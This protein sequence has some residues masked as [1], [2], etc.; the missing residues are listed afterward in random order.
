MY[1]SHLA[2]REQV[3]KGHAKRTDVFL[4]ACVYIFLDFF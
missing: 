1:A 2:M 3:W 4:C